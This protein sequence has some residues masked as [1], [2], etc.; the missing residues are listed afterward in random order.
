ME[1]KDRDGVYYQ[2]NELNLRGRVY[3]HFDKEKPFRAQVVGTTKQQFFMQAFKTRK[4]AEKYIK[5]FKPHSEETKQ[6]TKQHVWEYSDYPEWSQSIAKTTS[7]SDIEKRINTLESNRDKYAE[8]HL[9]AIEKSTSMQSNSQA[10]A[11]TGNVVRAN[12]EE[13]QAYKNA[14]EIQKNHPEKVKAK[15]APSAQ[16]DKSKTQPLATE[17]KA[18]DSLLSKELLRNAH[19]GTSFDPE[20]RAETEKEYFKIEVESVYKELK[21][22]AK[23]DK[24]KSELKDEMVKFQKRYAEKF[25]DTLAS[26]GRMLSPMIT[27]PANFPTRR[28]EKAYSSYENKVRENAK[29]RDKVVAGITKRWRKENIAEAGGERA[30]LEKK[31]KMAQENHQQMKDINK[32]MRKK[33]SDSDKRK[34]MENI[35]V[36][37]TLIRDVFKPDFMGRT[38]FQGFHL[39]NSNARIK[40]AKARLASMDKQEATK[41]TSGTINGVKVVDNTEDNRIQLFFDGKPDDDMRKKLKGSGW[42]WAPSVGAWQRIRTDNA[43]RS[44]EQILRSD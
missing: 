23:T 34:Q 1:S 5:T 9:K 12:Y 30:V 37:E 4:E 27:G 42:R 13:L 19:A 16:D 6:E 33:T 39:Q 11:Q 44:A 28:N 32:I 17:F 14:L 2:N 20:K 36:S 41:T 40:S 31:L 18:D 8:S 3:D 29:F 43:M 10:R 22:F 38:G 24:Q 25:N 35:G 15:S 7:K 26:R 21:G